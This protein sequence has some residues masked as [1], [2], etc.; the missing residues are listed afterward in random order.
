MM[1]SDAIVHG[2]V[3]LAGIVAY[4][5]LTALGDDGNPVL[6]AAFAW[7]GGAGTQAALPKR[8]GGV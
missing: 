8:T 6:A 5:V 2:A 7:A 1:I 3:I 4:V